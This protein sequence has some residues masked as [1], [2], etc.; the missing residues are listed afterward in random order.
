MPVFQVDILWAAGV[1]IKAE[2]AMAARE[3]AHQIIE[4]KLEEGVPLVFV[5]VESGDASKHQYEYKDGILTGG[6]ELRK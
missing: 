2:N 5:N 3:A 4:D 1:E 6:P